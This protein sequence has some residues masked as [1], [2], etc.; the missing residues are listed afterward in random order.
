MGRANKGLK[1]Q[2]QLQAAERQHLVED[3]VLVVP[4]GLGA[5]GTPVAHA[6]LHKWVHL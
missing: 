1:P 3:G 2:K 4:N 6:H 5:Q